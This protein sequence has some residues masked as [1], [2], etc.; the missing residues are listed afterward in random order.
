MMEPR[1]QNAN[2]G[3]PKNVWNFSSIEINQTEGASRVLIATGIIPDNESCRLQLHPGT[4]WC[5][6]Q[7][8]HVGST[9][10][11]LYARVAQIS[12]GQAWEGESRQY[13]IHSTQ[14]LN[15]IQDNRISL[16]SIDK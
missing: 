15:Q 4:E 1:E 10:P 8:P 12:C 14:N 16:M 7:Q 9:T 11:E 3:I 6:P 13:K 5:P 2:L